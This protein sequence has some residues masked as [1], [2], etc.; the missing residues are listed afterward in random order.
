MR[1]GQSREI[2]GLLLAWRAGDDRALEELI[3]KVYRELKHIAG[4]LMNRERA[5][6]T[7]VTTALV[8]EA[9]LRMGDLSAIDWNDRA[10][11]YSICSRIMRRV[12]VDHARSAKRQKRGGGEVYQ[13]DTAELLAVEADRRPADLVQLDEALDALG[14]Q[15]PEMTRIVEL[16]F[17]G[18]LDR[19][20]IAEVTGLSTA[21]VTRRW[22]AARAWLI[23]ELTEDP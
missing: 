14:K 17:F 19:E 2:T 13:A 9:Y 11:F 15:D 21:T 16:R 12:L 22:R 23:D 8:H 5:G 6:H 4:L 3:P 7:L 18:G 20:A 10:H 1:A